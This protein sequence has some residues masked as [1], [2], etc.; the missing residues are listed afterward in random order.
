MNETNERRSEPGS[1]L[2]PV[3]EMRPLPEDGK[4]LRFNSGQWTEDDGEWDLAFISAGHFGPPLA[5]G[6]SLKYYTNLLWSGL[7]THW[8]GNIGTHPNGNAWHYMLKPGCKKWGE[9]WLRDKHE[10]T[11]AYEAGMSRQSALHGCANGR[12]VE[13]KIGD[14]YIAAGLLRLRDTKEVVTFPERFRCMYCGDVE[15]LSLIPDMQVY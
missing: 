12:G 6:V 4:V 2:F 14:P 5:Y 7:T 3:Y 10:N 1:A 11:S 8:S 15:A 13:F 9:S